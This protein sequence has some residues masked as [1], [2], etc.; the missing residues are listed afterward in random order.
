MSC[1]LSPAFELK[2][3]HGDIDLIVNFCSFQDKPK[4]K[5]RIQFQYK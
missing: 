5:I 3:L 4:P 1:R 2:I